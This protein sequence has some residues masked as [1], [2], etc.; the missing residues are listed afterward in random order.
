M[1]E[2]KNSN[3]LKSFMKKEA[4]RLDISISNAYHT[5]AARKLLERISRDN[6][7]LL[8]VKGSA[9][10]ISYLGS[11]VR[12]VTDV[13]L[14]SLPRFEL[15]RDF[16]HRILLKNDGEQFKFTLQKK[17]YTTPTGIMKLSTQLNFDKTHQSLGID[18]ESNYRRLLKPEIRP[19]PVIF[20]GDEEFFI[21]VPSFEEYLAEKLCIIVES[22]K[23]DVLNT[24][25]KDFYDIYQLHGGKYSYKEL[26]KA[27]RKMLL[28]RGKI[29]L[30][31]ANTMHLDQKFIR[32]HK[33]VWESTKEKYD[34]LDREIDL[35][36]A[37]YYTR[38]VLREQ[39]Q[40]QGLPAPQNT[41]IKLIKS[42][43]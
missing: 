7:R 16:Y 18:Y 14:V 35:E 13:D 38:G 23:P 9:A 24:R 3:Q 11:L 30:E 1:I 34:F 6:N 32:E 20:E 8:L 37:V 31:E 15:N 22:N 29:S 19:V 25:V 4:A 40:K 12:A 43:R 42:A 36:G 27:F 28:L 33:D 17:P 2:F 10:E 26:T 41:N 5:F 21:R 39:L